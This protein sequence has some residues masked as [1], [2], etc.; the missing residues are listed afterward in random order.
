MATVHQR[1]AKGWEG[2]F[3]EVLIHAF[4]RF[5]SPSGFS[6]VEALKKGKDLEDSGPL[7]AKCKPT[8]EGVVGFVCDGVEVRLTGLMWM[9][10][11][12]RKWM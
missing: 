6:G 5:S 8:R 3:L 1:R 10:G 9:E 4:G 7:A 11:E 2:R 12:R